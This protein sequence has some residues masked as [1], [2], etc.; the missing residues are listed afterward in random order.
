MKYLFGFLLLTVFSFE[1]FAGNEK[2]MQPMGRIVNEPSAFV[3]KEADFDSQVIAELKPGGV[4]QISFKKFNEAFHRI[5]LVDGQIGYISDV[6]F[7]VVKGEIDHHVLN[8]LYGAQTNAYEFHMVGFTTATLK[9]TV[10]ELGCVVVSRK[11]DAGYNMIL[12]AKKGG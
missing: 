7:K 5:R 6:D 12:K 8:V 10:E 2:K 4:F 11:R 3:Y 1:A 9:E